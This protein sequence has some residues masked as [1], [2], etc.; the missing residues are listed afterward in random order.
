M[1]VTHLQCLFANLI[2]FWKNSSLQSTKIY[3]LDQILCVRLKHV[4]CL[5][6]SFRINMTWNDMQ[7]LIFFYQPDA[8]V[9]KSVIVIAKELSTW[10]ESCE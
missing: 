3:C 8:C 10:R 7:S 9:A 5:C 1:Y 6:Y 4:M 2:R